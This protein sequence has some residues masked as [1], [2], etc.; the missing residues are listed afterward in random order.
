MDIDSLLLTKKELQYQIDYILNHNIQPVAV[1]LTPLASSIAQA[2][3]DKI[4]RAGH[5]HTEETFPP[6]GD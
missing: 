5:L 4:K 6:W 2:Q 1:L 3:L